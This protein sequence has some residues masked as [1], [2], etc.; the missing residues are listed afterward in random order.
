MDRRDQIIK[1]FLAEQGWDM[2]CEHPLELE[3]S[4]EEDG[5]IGFA[6][7][8]IAKWILETVVD[9]HYRRFEEI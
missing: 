8:Q 5:R 7:G 4:T 1:D 2:V 3:M 9:D 6:S